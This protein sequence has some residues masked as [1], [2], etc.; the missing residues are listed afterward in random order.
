[1]EA[2]KLNL[3]VEN[4]LLSISE[5]TVRSWLFVIWR[6][7]I[8]LRLFLFVVAYSDIKTVSNYTHYLAL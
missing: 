7:F 6:R 3:H 2:M 5:K 8:A 4:V 1:M